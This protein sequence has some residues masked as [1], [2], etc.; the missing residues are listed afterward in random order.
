ML[1]N[2]SRLVFPTLAALTLSLTGGVV[3]AAVPSA[4]QASK[5]DSTD[6]PASR[7]QLKSQSE[8]A[9][10]T[11]V[12]AT[13][14]ASDKSVKDALKATDL[15]GAKKQT[16]KAGVFTGTVTK[17]FAPKSNAL[18]ILNFASDYKTAITAVVRQRSFSA[19]PALSSLEGKKVV[20]SGTVT[21]YQNRPEIEL[22][23]SSQI[24]LVK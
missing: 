2:R 14:T 1:I 17:V 19:F 4:P 9:S 11:A 8:S 7:P 6:K 10:K 12:F 15:E 23:S 16:G 22:T 5:Q 3:S 24:K 13:V 20:I 18:V 21:S